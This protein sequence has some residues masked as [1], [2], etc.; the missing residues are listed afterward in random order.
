M[1]RMDP[2]I[3]Q[4]IRNGDAL[5]MKTLYQECFQELFAFGFKMIADKEKVKDCLHEIFCDIWQKRAQ[6]GEVN[7]VKAYLKTCVRNRLLKEIKL[8]QKTDQISGQEFEYLTEN[9]YEQLLISAETDADTKVKIW[10]AINELTQMQREI[11]KL[12]FFDELNYEAIAMML[13]LKP[14]TVYNHMYAAICKLRDELSA[15]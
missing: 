10:R 15:K 5:A 4:N 12:K 9:S 7:H 14:R 1:F 6:V 8:D 13:K 2:K 3:W 11:I